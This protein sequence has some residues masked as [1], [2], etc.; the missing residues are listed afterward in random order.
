MEIQKGGNLKTWDLRKKEEN[1]KG[2]KGGV[3]PKTRTKSGE[4]IKGREKRDERRPKRRSS[5]EGGVLGLVWGQ[6]WG[7]RRS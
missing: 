2:Q 1:L 5:V 6:D 7:V 4:I 3:C